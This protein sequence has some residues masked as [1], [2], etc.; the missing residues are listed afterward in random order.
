MT[1]TNTQSVR[2]EAESATAVTRIPTFDEVYAMPYVQE[3]IA[4]IIERDIQKHPLLASYRD[5]LRQEL[6]IKLHDLLPKYDGRAGIKTFVRSCLENAII[7]ARRQYF[8]EQN[9]MIT[10]ASDI[11]D[12]DDPDDDSKGLNPEDVRAFVSL[13]RNNIEDD[14]CLADLTDAIGTLPEPEKEIALGLLNGESV[15]SIERRL[16]LSNSSIS[17]NYV[18]TIRKAVRKLFF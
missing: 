1:Q 17:R 15:R 5:D 14:M 9:L 4:A 10:R 18:K 12:F 6:L 16:G 8:R 7:N 3:T 2:N 13:C 11:S